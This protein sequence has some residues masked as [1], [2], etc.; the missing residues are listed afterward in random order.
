MNPKAVDHPSLILSAP[1][2]VGVE[3][4]GP[5][6][7]SRTLFLNGPADALTVLRTA[8]RHQVA[9][10]YFGASRLSAFDT[11]AILYCM[12]HSSLS[13]TVEVGDWHTDHG[14]ALLAAVSKST[15]LNLHLVVTPY[16]LLANRRVYHDNPA[17][18]ETVN[19]LRDRV[20][21]LSVK[22]DTGD[23]VS[24]ISLGPDGVHVNNFDNYG[25]DFSV[26]LETDEIT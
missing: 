14:S 26:P 22:Y 25:D 9:H 24:L 3:Q 17:V 21:T 19:G 2:F 18:L 11:R 12:W 1:A 4:E 20:R 15:F 5:L 16:M 7:G 10:V 8:K 13:V 23:T 6:R